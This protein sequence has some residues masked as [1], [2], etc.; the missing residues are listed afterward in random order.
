MGVSMESLVEPFVERR[1]DF[2]LF[3][4][5]V[6]HRLSALGDIDFII[7]TLE[8]NE[9]EVYYQKGWYPESLYLLA[10]L[11]YIS[12]ENNVPLCTKYDNLR[13]TKLQ[14]PLYPAS[15]IAAAEISDDS[16]IKTEA[17]KDSIPEFA[18]FNIIENEVRNVI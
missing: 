6:C 12:R 4:S 11:D 7:K 16:T 13:K 5:N 10:M 2:D 3:R 8:G 15:I 17:R 9:I 18:R 1:G 14:E